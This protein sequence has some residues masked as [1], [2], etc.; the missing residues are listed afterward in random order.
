MNRIYNHATC[1]TARVV[2][3]TVN[4]LPSWHIAKH[5]AL[6]PHA[7]LFTAADHQRL[8]GCGGGNG[9]SPLQHGQTDERR[10][11]GSG[12]ARMRNNHGR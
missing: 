3:A 6:V 9:R 1:W 5:D 12:R 8:G 4:D 2:I 11:S 7:P 10:G